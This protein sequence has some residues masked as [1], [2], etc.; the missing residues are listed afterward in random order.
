ML[1]LH[2][3][4]WQDVVLSLI[5]GYGRAVP[6]HGC[7]KSGKPGKPGKVR[8]FFFGQGKPGNPGKVREFFFLNS[9]FFLLEFFSIKFLLLI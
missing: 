1:N 2:L 4:W 6:D 3:C 5:L 7:H 9:N 8:D